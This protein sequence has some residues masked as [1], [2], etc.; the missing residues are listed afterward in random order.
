MIIFP[1]G[2]VPT[3]Y[4][5]YFWNCRTK[6]LS[7]IKIGG[8]LREIQM[9]KPNHWN[10]LGNRS[11]GRGMDGGYRVSHKGSRVWLLVADLMELEE[12]QTI[13][14]EATK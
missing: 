14:P 10:N 7:S 13:F 5:G 2:Y 11:K 8:E 12:T 1:Y 9:Q 4:P 6:K 3:K